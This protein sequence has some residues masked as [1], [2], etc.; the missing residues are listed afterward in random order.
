MYHKKFYIL[1]RHYLRQ[2]VCMLYSFPHCRTCTHNCIMLLTAIYYT[3]AFI[4]SH[5]LLWTPAQRKRA[6]TCYIL[7]MFFFYLFFLWPPYS[8]ALVNR[9]SRQLYYTWWI[10]SGIREFTTLIFSWSSLN[11]RVG[12]KVTKFGVFSDRTHRLSALTTERGR[13]L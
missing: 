4:V 12:Q 1:Y 3:H 11:Y 6:S 7:P 2:T 9:G 10:L 8:P 13:R 5:V